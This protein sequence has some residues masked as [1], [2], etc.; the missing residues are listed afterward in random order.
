MTMRNAIALFLAIALVSAGGC[1]SGRPETAPVHGRI[2]YGSKPV[3]SGT[4]YF[5]P[6]KGVQARGQIGPDGV[7]TLNTYEQGDGAVLGKHTVT[8]EATRVKSDAPEI[9][10]FEEEVA[11][12]S[13]PKNK[14]AAK[15]VVEYLVPRKYANRSTTDLTRVVEAKDNVI[16]FD[17]P[18]TP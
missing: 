11:Y 13:N 15:P 8:I 18:A 17:I 10:S 12:Y 2:T 14:L 3:E 1:G 16:N 4:I 5:W 7:Y 9:N 6:E